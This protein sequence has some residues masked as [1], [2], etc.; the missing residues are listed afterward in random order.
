MRLFALVSSLLIGA[1]SVIG[2]R[3]GTEEPRFEVVD[4][5]GEVELRRYGARL[6]AETVVAAGS[7]TAAR[8]E[9]FRR[10]AGYIFGGNRPAS[11]I[12]MTAPVDQAAE[13]IA[14]TAPVGATAAGEGQWRIRFYMPAGFTLQTLPA[15]N[16]PRIHLLEVPAEVVAVRRYS[17]LRSADAA[18]AQRAALLAAL[19]DSPWQAAGAAGDWFYDPPWTLPPL[20]RNEAVVPVSRR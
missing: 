13:R 8:S 15:P 11:R 10:L 7:E 20:R 2:V 1:C 9:G 18:A 4:R 5:I 3:S 12:A 17:G 14:M 19:A 6:A 16:D